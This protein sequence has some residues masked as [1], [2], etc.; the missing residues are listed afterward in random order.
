MTSF[1]R[2]LR[3]GFFSLTLLP[4]AVPVYGAPPD[5]AGRMAVLQEVVVTAT[6]DQE[7]IRKVPAHVTVIT[8]K[9]IRDSGATS[10]V[11]ILERQEGIQFRSYSGHEP[12]S[13]I[14]LRGMGG[15]SP[16]GKVQIQLNGRRLNRPDMASVNWFQIPL[17]QVERIEIVRGAG[18]VLYGDSAV[19]GVINI[20]TRKGEGRPVFHTSAVAGSYGLHDEKAAV[21][22][23]EKK[24]S[25]AVSGENYFS[26]GYRNR[27]TVSSQGAGLDLAYDAGDHLGLSMGASFNRTQYELPGNLTAAEMAMDRRQYQPARPAYWTSASSN[28]DGTDRQT[29]LRFRIDSMLGDFGR[30][31]IGFSAGI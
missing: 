2:F 18:S 4:C 9:E 17:S 29:E 11:E 24:W 30:A 21:S 19:A 15:D 10:L 8:E 1:S 12:L 3:F 23:S 14:D 31:E 20:I 28:D 26:L 7:E 5:D 16:F 6:R 13:I 27:S 25:Y 22:G